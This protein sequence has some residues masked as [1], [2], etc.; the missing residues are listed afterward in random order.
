MVDP[1]RATLALIAVAILIIVAMPLLW[2]GA[3]MGNMMGPGMMGGWGWGG[4]INPWWGVLSI[5]FGTLVV[6]GLGL[7]V[8]WAVRQAG[9]GEAGRGRSP[10]DI[11][12]ERYARGD[13][14]REQYEQMRRDLES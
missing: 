2:G 8:V 6:A 9:P 4:A 5:L 14:T 10:L 1:T 11:L 7:L 12:K 3:M 13:L